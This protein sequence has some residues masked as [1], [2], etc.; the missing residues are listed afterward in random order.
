MVLRVGIHQSDIHVS[1][2]ADSLVVEGEGK[3]TLDRF[4]HWVH[5]QRPSKYPYETSFDMAVYITKKD[6][7][8]AGEPVL[9][10]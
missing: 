3:R 6:I 7:G 10:S 4:C 1:Y 8:P 5:Y 2:Q 9:N